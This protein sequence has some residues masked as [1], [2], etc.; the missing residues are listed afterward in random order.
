[1]VVFCTRQLLVD[2]IVSWLAVIAA[3]LTLIRSLVEYLRDRKAIDAATAEILLK[4]NAEALDAIEK[5]NKARE[6]VRTDTA[7]NPAGVMSDDG[8]KRPD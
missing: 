8:F 3:A 2:D 4:S 6:L 1:V 5:A 7:R